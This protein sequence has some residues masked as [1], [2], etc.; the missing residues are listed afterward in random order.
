[1]AE[2]RLQ[3]GITS[4]VKGVGKNGL[5]FSSMRISLFVKTGPENDMLSYRIDG[6]RNP[7]L[8]LKPNSILKITFLN[9]DDDMFHDICF[10]KVGPPFAMVPHIFHGAIS[11]R[12]QHKNSIGHFGQILTVKVPSIKGKYTYFCTVA[13]HAKGGM[14][15]TIWVK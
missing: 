5:S 12:V 3:P 13:G 14:Y 4:T 11:S 15:G 6:K 8:I 1:M 7:T 10:S 2:N 9:E